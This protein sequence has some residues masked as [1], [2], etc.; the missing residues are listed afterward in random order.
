M[1]KSKIIIPALGMLLLSTAAS[2]TGTVAWFTSVS[3]QTANINSFAV[4]RLGGNLELEIKTAAD[5]ADGSIYGNGSAKSGEAVTLAANS[6]FTHG[7]YNHTEQ[8]VYKP[9]NAAATTFASFADTSATATD[10]YSE[11]AATGNKYYYAVTWTYIFTYTFGSTE[12]SVNLYFD[13]ANSSVTQTVG[14]G[15]GDL[16]TYKGFRMAFVATGESLT[17]SVGRSF[18][19]AKYGDSTGTNIPKYLKTSGESITADGTYSNINSTTAAGDLINSAASSIDIAENAPVS[20][21]TNTRCN[22]IGTFTKSGSDT[23]ASKKI[24]VRC[25][26]WFEGTDANVVNAATLDT[27]AA[28]NAFYTRNAA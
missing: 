27:V 14:A 8:K 4:K 2:V 6:F 15:T 25:V 19:W 11:D 20:D 17:G 5:N 18:V 10:W 22:Y 1:K 12:T 23:N 24:F 13:N 9:T 3:S 7:S 21:V 26:A 16:N 28:V